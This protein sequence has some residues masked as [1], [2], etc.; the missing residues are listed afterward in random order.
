[1]KQIVGNISGAPTGTLQNSSTTS[2]SKA[3]DLHH[4]SYGFGNQDAA[5]NLKPSHGCCS[6]ID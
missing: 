2:L 4:H 1:M 5:T 3:S 6:W